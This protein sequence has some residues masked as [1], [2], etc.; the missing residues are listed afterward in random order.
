MMVACL[1]MPNVWRGDSHHEC[2]MIRAPMSITCLTITQPARLAMLRRAVVDFSRQE[3]AARELLIVHDAGGE[4][5]SV[6]RDLIA[7]F[8]DQRIRTHTA[9]A[10]TSLGELRNR[11]VELAD[12]E[13]VC[14]WDDDDRYHPLRLSMQLQALQAESADLCFLG[15]QLHWFAARGEMYWTD[16]NIEPYPLN[17]VQ[18]TMLGRR[19]CLPRY[20]DLLRGEDTGLCLDI[21]RAGRRIARMREFAWLYVYVFHGANAW[22]AAHHQAISAHK[23]LNGAQLLA[24]KRV[25]ETRLGEYA[26]PLRH[27]IMPSRTGDLIFD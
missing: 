23:S 25:L 16:W 19:D 27:I 8:P 12:S 17:F 21:L 11:S 18:G 9:P 20:P 22:S 1:S 24:R 13:F 3:Y 5:E 15:D 10:G 6:L 14:Q 7:D 26:P 4:F 2:T